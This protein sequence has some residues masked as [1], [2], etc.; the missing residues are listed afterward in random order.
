MSDLPPL[1]EV[2]RT[3]GLD[4]RKGL[5]QHFLLDLNLT[6]K[7]VRAAGDLSGRDVLEVGPGPGGLTRPLL[8]SDADRVVAVERDARCVAALQDVKAA[9][10]G[11]LEIVEGDAL[12]ADETALVRPGAAVVANLP[13]NVGT[14]LLFK[15]L[16]QPEHVGSM[17]LM[18]QKE[19]ADRIVAAP[20]SGQYGRL[21]VMSNWRWQST[22]LFEL[23]ARAFT[24]PPKVASAV[25]HLVP[26]PEPLAPADGDALSRV[27]AQAFNQRR[28]MLRQ[29][30][31]GLGADASALL[32]AA[33]IDP[34]RRAE[35]L[36][37]K[38]FCALARAFQALR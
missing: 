8:E 16:A 10:P 33:G 30:L 35:T 37:I 14:P 34:T 5:G 22:K 31:K 18:F 1:R 19:V 2:I 15:W 32:D 36:S 27:V 12:E 3:Y 13:Y 29:S 11:R 7:I 4:A 24:P 9:F 28:K 17:T 25:V 26:R 20:G 23:P 21:A 38:E 6:A